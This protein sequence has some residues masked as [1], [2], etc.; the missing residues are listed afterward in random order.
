[1]KTRI[2]VAVFASITALVCRAS[3]GGVDQQ[4]LANAIAQA[5]T[6]NP[7]GLQAIAAGQ[8]SQKI[9]SS[10]YTNNSAQSLCD[11]LTNQFSNDTNLAGLSTNAAGVAKNI[12]SKVFATTITPE[13][14]IALTQELTDLNNGLNYQGIIDN[15]NNVSARQGG[16]ASLRNLGTIF[17]TLGYSTNFANDL[18]NAVVTTTSSPV[19]AQLAGLRP[20]SPQDKAKRSVLAKFRLERPGDDIITMQDDLASGNASSLQSDAATLGNDLYIAG[21]FEGY[22]PQVANHLFPNTNGFGLKY[23]FFISPGATFQSPFLVS[24]NQ[25][26]GTA[27][28]TNAGSSTVGTLDFNFID[29]YVLRPQRA[30]YYG[31]ADDGRWHY[32]NKWGESGFLGGLRNIVFDPDFDWNIGILFANGSPSSSGSNVYSSST[33]AGSGNFWVNTSV[34]FPLL[35]SRSDT[36]VQ[37]ITAEISGGATTDEKFL[38]VH[39]SFLVGGGYQGAWYNAPTLVGSSTN[40]PAFVFSRVGYGFIDMPVLSTSTNLNVKV[41]NL[42]QYQLKWAPALATGLYYPLGG[43]VYFSLQMNAYFMKNPAP[44]NITVGVSMPLNKIGDI[45]KQ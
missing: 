12:A 23:M 7:P 24:Y 37:Q 5:L 34:G 2:F 36:F 28:L 26:N 35:R 43:G 29:R 4:A 42:P 15:D 40:N 39:P 1:M 17:I 3:G 25:A 13:A 30:N 44:W 9:A 27:S 14:K 33:I 11:C 31:T 32:I 45:F 21:T 19:G 10:C 18:Q 20:P 16:G 6:N 38:A 22:G 8:E 41:T